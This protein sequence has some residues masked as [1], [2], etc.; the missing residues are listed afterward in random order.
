M[1]Y[2]L[3]SN[4]ISYMLR[5][6]GNVLSNFNKE[7][8][9]LRNHYAIP[10]IVAHEVKRWLLYKPTKIIKDYNEKFN[11]L[12]NSVKHRAEMPEIIW[13]KATDIYIDLKS[14]GQLIG[15]SDIII[16]A[17]CIVN[18]HMLVTR[19]TDDFNR[20]NGLKHVNWFD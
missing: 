2:T 9:E 11:G 16:A 5:K 18:N 19:N 15:N 8:A 1:I 3:D 14:R 20:I 7:I 4:T 6:E 17:Y 10:F 13:D 12:F